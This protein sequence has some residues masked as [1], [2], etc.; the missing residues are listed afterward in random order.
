MRLFIVLIIIPSTLFAQTESVEGFTS[1]NSFA[2]IKP[3]YSQGIAQKQVCFMFGAS[4][5]AN[6][7]NC[8]GTASVGNPTK[9]DKVLEVSISGGAT[10]T[11]CC[12]NL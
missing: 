8:T 5:A 12:E 6:I 1:V 2:S 9:D 3:Y 11:I 10:Q 4:P 7:T